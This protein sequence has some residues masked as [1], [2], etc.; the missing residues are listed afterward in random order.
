MIGSILFVGELREKRGRL[1]FLLTNVLKCY[2][3]K[4]SKS[5]GSM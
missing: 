2:K 1:P 4:K 3:K 5:S